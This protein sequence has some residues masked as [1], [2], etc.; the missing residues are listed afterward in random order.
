MEELGQKWIARVKGSELESEKVWKPEMEGLRGIAQCSSS[1]LKLIGQVS[2]CSAGVDLD[3][4]CGL[5]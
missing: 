2:L 1:D 4:I 3:V 5:L